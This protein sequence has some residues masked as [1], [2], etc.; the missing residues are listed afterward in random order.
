MSIALPQEGFGA[1][2]HACESEVRSAGEQFESGHDL[3]LVCVPVPQYCLEQADQADQAPMQVNAAVQAWVSVAESEFEHI[4]SG[5]VLVRVCVPDP[6]VTEQD[7]QADQAPIK[8]FKHRCIYVQ[9]TMI[10]SLP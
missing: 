2:V 8:I 7:D 1:M 9:C 6:Q 10:L 4:E 3:V 5:Q